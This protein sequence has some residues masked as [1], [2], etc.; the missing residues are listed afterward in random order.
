M[1]SRPR[2]LYL[3]GRVWSRS[4]LGSSTAPLSVLI[5][6]R[7]GIKILTAIRLKFPAVK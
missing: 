4:R 6:V 2:I 5:A 3:F 7:R 1:V